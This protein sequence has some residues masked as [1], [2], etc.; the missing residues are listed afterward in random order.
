VIG[1]LTGEAYA[2][3]LMDAASPLK[4]RSVHVCVCGGIAAYKAVEVVRRLQDAGARVQV[5]MTPN[6]QRFVG[7]LTFQSITHAPVL[8][9]TLDATEELE[10]GHIAFAQRCDALLVVPATAN[11]LAK[12]AHGLGDEVVSTVLLAARPRQ[13]PVLLA[14]AMNTAMWENEATAEN[15]AVLRRRGFLVVEPDAG[16]L[17]CGAVGP[18]RLAPAEQL[19]S[20]VVEALVAR[21]SQGALLGR[22]VLVTAGPTREPLDPARFLSNASTGK[23]GFAVARA[24]QAAG[25]EVTVVHGPVALVPPS[26]VRTVSVVTAL[27][28]HAAVFAELDGPTP[29]DAIFMTA[30]V[31]DFRPAVVAVSKVKKSTAPDRLELLR[32]P[33]I[34]AEL[35]ARRGNGARPVLVGFA[36]ESGPPVDYARQKLISKRVDLVVANDI[37]AEGAGFGTDTNHVWLVD[38]SEVEELSMRSKDAVAEALVGWLVRRLGAEP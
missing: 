12:F 18:G 19:V 30:A 26:G 11:A 23:A 27:E 16:A 38:P 7:P 6:A 1:A 4:G 10:I 21:G 31:A 29:P 35:G 33:D 20:A 13:T 32:N 22:R 25:A 3:P 5:A 15:L 2:T 14:P 28:M 8:T 24:C 9:E 37:T 36:A 17:A 34:L